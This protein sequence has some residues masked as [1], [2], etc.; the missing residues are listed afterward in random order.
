MT[1]NIKRIQSGGYGS[2]YYENC[3]LFVDKNK[4][5]FMRKANI[6]IKYILLKWHPFL[7][8]KKRISYFHIMRVTYIRMLCNLNANNNE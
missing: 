4:K 6:T 7:I 8:K 2:V 1:V 5:I 3:S